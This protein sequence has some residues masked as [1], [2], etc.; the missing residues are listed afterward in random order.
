MLALSY[1]CY[2]HVSCSFERGQHTA[3][4][5]ETHQ[6]PGTAPSGKK[7]GDCPYSGGNR[8]KSLRVVTEKNAF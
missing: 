7:K 3:L 2:G 4:T 8:L 1:I 5:M 6:L